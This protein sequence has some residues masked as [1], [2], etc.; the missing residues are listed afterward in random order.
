MT[1]SASEQEVTAATRLVRAL[2]ASAP[3]DHFFGRFPRNA[4]KAVTV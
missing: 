1:G 2:T 4:R 3:G